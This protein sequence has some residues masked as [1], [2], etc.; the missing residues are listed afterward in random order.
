MIRWLLSW[1]IETRFV[2]TFHDGT[3]RRRVDPYQTCLALWSEQN[4]DPDELLAVVAS[5]PLRVD[6]F[7]ATSTL[8]ANVRKAFHVKQLDDGGLTD[9]ECVDLLVKFMDMVGTV[10]KNTSNSPIAAPSTESATPV[11]YSLDDP[12]I[13]LDSDYGP[14]SAD[15]S[16]A[17]VTN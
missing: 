16:T 5:K 4:F 7:R 17:E 6:V 1:V 12:P 14:I 8:A 3:K 11:T 10:K 9:G 2:F 13:K 15:N